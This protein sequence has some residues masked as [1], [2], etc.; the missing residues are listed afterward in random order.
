M[1]QFE[2]FLHSFNPNIFSIAKCSLVFTLKLN[3]ITN[4]KQGKSENKSYNTRTGTKG[5]AHIPYR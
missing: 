2:R 1:R 5:E 4:W 3:K